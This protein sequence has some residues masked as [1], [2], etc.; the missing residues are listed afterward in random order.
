MIGL[1]RPKLSLKLTEMLPA[2]FGE[3]SLKM[4]E[5]LLALVAELICMPSSELSELTLVLSY[6]GGHDRAVRTGV[7]Q[8]LC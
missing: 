5:V 3:L 2:L 1:N 4:T 8:R 6:D 7:I